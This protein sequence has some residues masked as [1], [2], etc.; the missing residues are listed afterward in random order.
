MKAL[1]GLKLSDLQ[2]S[3][4]W[5]SERKLA[6]VRAWFDPEDLSNFEPIPVKMLDGR[7]VMTDGHTRAAAAVMAGL[8]SVPLCAEED[9]LDWELYRACVEECA[10]RG[11]I[12][13]E[14]LAAR[15]IPE[16]EYRVKWDGWCDELHESIAGAELTVRRYTRAEI[17]DVLAFERALR[18][19][20][21]DWGWEIDEA[22]EKSVTESFDDARFTNSLSYLAYRRG[23]VIGRIDAVLIPSHFDGSV[24]AY[25][26]W[27]CVLKS[28]RHRGA[29][30]KLMAALREELA[31]RGVDTLIAL[32][33][34]NEEAQRFYKS[35]PD[36][37]MRDTGI[38]I[39]IK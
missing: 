38:W 11:V 10:K 35:V 8:E 17:P 37:L 4:F 3:Q 25:L 26:D 30:Q 7:P 28:C 2:P 20:E 22:Y 6:D 18:D 16:E 21:D 23:R 5:I 19:E 36:S 27:I 32:T 12:S 34:S 29:A 13:P 15:V 1:S 24:K 31:R 9:E 33:A 39:D 14:Q